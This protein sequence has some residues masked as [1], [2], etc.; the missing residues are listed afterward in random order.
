MLILNK[1]VVAVADSGEGPGGPGPPPPLFLD[2][3]RKNFFGDPVP[4]FLRVWMTGLPPTP[5]PSLFLISRSGSGT[6]LLLHQ[7]KVVSIS[8]INLIS[9]KE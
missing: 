9:G 8:R 7:L 6:V 4:P 2:Q 3:G 5:L 1:L